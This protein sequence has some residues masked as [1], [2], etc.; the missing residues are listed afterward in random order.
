ML[1][2]QIRTDKELTSVLKNNQTPEWNIVKEFPIYKSV[3]E[4]VPEILIESIDTAIPK[5]LHSLK[6]NFAELANSKQN[7]SE[8]PLKAYKFE[9]Q[10]QIFL[11]LKFLKKDVVDPETNY[12]NPSQKKPLNE[13]ERKK[14]QLINDVKQVDKQSQDSY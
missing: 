5:V 4:A 1:R 7:I 10:K 9:G 6:I 14:Q 8:F 11:R 13:E 12:T 2:V 3:D